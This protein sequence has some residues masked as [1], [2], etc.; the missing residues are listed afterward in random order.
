MVAVAKEV[1]PGRTRESG[2]RCYEDFAGVEVY[3]HPLRAETRS[4]CGKGALN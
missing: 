4:G 3:E 1:A 2:G